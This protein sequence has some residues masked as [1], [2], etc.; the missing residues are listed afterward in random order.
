M[1][2]FMSTDAAV[3]K[4]SSQQQYEKMS[5]VYGPKKFHFVRSASAKKEREMK[6]AQE[7]LVRSGS[8]AESMPLEGRDSEVLHAV[9]A[10]EEGRPIADTPIF[11]DSFRQELYNDDGIDGMV[12]ETMSAMGK[13]SVSSVGIAPKSREGP[14]VYGL[15]LEDFD[16][17]E[18]HLFEGFKPIFGSLSKQGTA[19]DGS[20][21]L[22]ADEILRTLEGLDIGKTT[23]QDWSMQ[24]TTDLLL[25]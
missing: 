7:K 11:D 25:P 8:S 24:Y 5:D 3:K 19:G 12:R 9:F 14:E 17:D 6:E 21:E 15:R 16:F 1:V 20:K 23:H 13:H 18:E 22:S 2:L 10:D 4:K